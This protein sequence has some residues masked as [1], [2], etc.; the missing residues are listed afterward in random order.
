MPASATSYPAHSDPRRR[1]FALIITVV[2]V[3]FVVL[4][5]V[6]LATFTRVETSVAENSAKLGAARQNALVALNIALGKLQETA[7]P[8]ERVT[9]TAEASDA[10]AVDGARYWTGV[11]DTSGSNTVPDEGWLVSGTNPSPTTAIAH[12]A[13]PTP[14][15]NAVTLVGDN[16]ADLTDLRVTVPLTD[17]R[18]PESQIPGLGT[19]AAL[20]TIGRVGWWVG[21]EGV[22]ASMALPLQVDVPTYAPYDTAT[23]RR[24]LRT[25]VPMGPQDFVTNDASSTDT[26]AGFDP[27]FV[28]A[29]V[30][31]SF[32][33]YEQ[34]QFLTPVPGVSNWSVLLNE[35]FHSHT[36]VASAVLAG[37]AGGGLKR[38]LSRQPALLGNAFV[39]YSNPSTHV[40]P[41]GT[42]RTA[43]VYTPLI[44][45]ENDARREHRLIPPVTSNVEVNLTHSVAPHISE[46]Y[47]Q[48]IPFYTNTFAPVVRARAYVALWNPYNSI[49]ILPPELIVE[50]KG[51]PS[52]DFSWNTSPTGP[53][54]FTRSVNLETA[55]GTASGASG[56]AGLRLRIPIPAGERALSPGRVVPFS[57]D[58]DNDATDYELSKFGRR[59]FLPVS[60]GGFYTRSGSPFWEVSPGGVPPAYTQ[61]LQSGWS[62]SAPSIRLTATVADSAAPG[63]VLSSADLAEFTGGSV[64][65]TGVNNSRTLGFASRIQQFVLD[66]GVPETGKWWWQNGGVAFDPREPRHIYYNTEDPLDVPALQNPT[67]YGDGFL[68]IQSLVSGQSGGEQHYRKVPLFE[69]PRLPIL[70][71]GALQHM[72]V[73]N[74]QAF[75]IGNS[76]GGEGDLWDKFFF[77][78]LTS[79]VGVPPQGAPLPN[80]HLANLADT[81]ASLV[82]LNAFTS[83]KILIRGAF[84]VNSID[85]SA[86][87]ALL[88]SLRPFAAN[89]WRSVDYLDAGNGF[90]GG[91]IAGEGTV[92]T[93]R[94]S[95]RGDKSQGVG[96]QEEIASRASGFARFSQTAQELWEY[97]PG[98]AGTVNPAGIDRLRY[99][100]GI[101]AGDDGTA[102]IAIRNLPR[103]SVDDLAEEIADRV[104]DRIR[105]DGPFTSMADFL[106]ADSSGR[107]L[108]EEAVYEADVNLVVDS[109]NPSSP[110]SSSVWRDGFSSAWLSQADILTAIGP[111]LTNR[112][113]TFLIRT[114]GDV[115]NPVTGEV[116][117]RAWCEAR[118]QRI[119]DTVDSSDDIDNPTQ[120]FGRRF[121]VLNF[122]WLGREDI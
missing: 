80:F 85:Q 106:N 113:D 77:S 72:Q 21:D 104:R 20:T 64:G 54:L 69:L 47:L 61:V 108:L 98:A 31:S 32:L 26:A 62:I 73:S 53:Q 118:V 82:G 25:Q 100:S 44:T 110:V 115:V 79:Q 94:D 90:S 36:T 50:V 34:A 30:M 101:R 66:P 11:W 97:N 111:Q 43:G 27:Q 13:T 68:G 65:V 75:S 112:S 8:D 88:Q 40:V 22:K 9:A 59:E 7:G 109:P 16:T 55:Y 37:T 19:G 81:T 24:I 48:F 92:T 117:A 57:P 39:Q 2:L 102:Q 46:I 78:G 63:V 76:W 17:L 67:D 51:L 23:A 29:P 38:D 33:S 41:V 83:R 86:W 3:A 45:D 84:N 122:R 70:S 14:A 60:G 107:S 52:V 119:P 114:Y 56:G 10:G 4:I 58:R 120:P 6:G 42:P 12:I 99:M 121:V 74:G 87:R 35:N 103:D 93:V 71:L 1:G 95:T 96:S 89:D 18:V 116:E 49:I 91:T 28:G 15:Q 105:A 5:L